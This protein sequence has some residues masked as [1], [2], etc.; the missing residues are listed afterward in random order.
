M[1]PAL[2]QAFCDRH[3]CTMEYARRNGRGIELDELKIM[4]V[5][6]VVL[7]VFSRNN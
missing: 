4:V 7:V 3:A 2:W 5:A 6:R 1:R